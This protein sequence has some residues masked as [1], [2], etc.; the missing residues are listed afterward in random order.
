MN[1]L[2]LLTIVSGIITI[3]GFVIPDKFRTNKYFLWIS[4][5][6]VVFVSGWLVQL[7]TKLERTK[8]VQKAAVELINKRNMKFTN[9]GFIQAGL[10]FME[11]NKDLYPD[12]YQRA[13]QIQD[14]VKDVWYSECEINAASEME[15][16][17]YGIA[18]LNKD[19]E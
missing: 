1:Y 8:S 7:N 3:V 11:E 16:L 19:K 9:R 2:L 5:V 14:K 4:F 17:I 12:S 18:I 13:I 15:G 6:I 10:S